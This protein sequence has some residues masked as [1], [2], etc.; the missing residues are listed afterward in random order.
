MGNTD[1]GRNEPCPCG[2]GRKYK[3]CCLGRE[4][5]PSRSNPADEVNEELRQAIQG[6]QFATF[7]DA[8]AFIADFTRQRNHRPIDDF[9]GLSSEQ[10]MRILNFPFESPQFVSFPTCLDKEPEAPILALFKLLTDAIG[11]QGL[12]PTATGNL[13]LKVVRDAALAYWGEDRYKKNTE[14][15]DIRTEPEFYDLHATRLIAELAGLVRKY[16]GKFILSRE[17]RKLMAESGMRA[18]YPRLFQAYARRFNWGYRDGYPELRFI[19]Q[20]FVFTLYLLHR[21][22]G[23]WRPNAFYEDAFLRAF[24]Q[25]IEEVG[26]VT[27]DTP[28][29]QLRRCYSSRTLDG[30]AAFLGLAE[31]RRES[32]RWIDSRF[33]V[34]SLP[35]LHEAMVFHL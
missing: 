20:S 4:A 27:Y 15:G 14:L 19:Q 25:V 11:E 18:I 9:C 2:S 16:K 10:M 35:L 6:Q 12:K 8:Q 1:I 13:P 17:C 7:A 23:E 24:P 22:G 32:E 26:P 21:F 28:E 30:F 29:G 33:E 34:R 5:A 31:I 3:H